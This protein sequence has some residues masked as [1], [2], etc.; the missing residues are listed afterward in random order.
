MHARRNDDG[1]GHDLGL[2]GL[3]AGFFDF[4]RGELA[5]VF[6]QHLRNVVFDGKRKRALGALKFRSCVIKVQR[7]LTDGADENI[8]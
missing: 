4:F 1:K 3:D 8:G 2:R 6:H 7:P 5:R